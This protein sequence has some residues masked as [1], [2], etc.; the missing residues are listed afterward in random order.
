M[1]YNQFAANR[2]DYNFHLPNTFLPERFLKPYHPDDDM[3]S[4]QPFHLGRH[5]CIGLKLAWAEMRVVIARV[6]Y[7]FDLR[8]ADEK[9][10]CDWGDQKSYIT[11]VKRPLN[12]VIEHVEVIA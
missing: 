7:V 2:Q 3:A 12:V 5:Q 10:R 9:E 4:F 8:L 11:W 6:L 1:A